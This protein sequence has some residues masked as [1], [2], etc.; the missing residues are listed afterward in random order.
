MKLSDYIV[1]LLEERN[2]KHVFGYPGGMI[3][4][5]M[6]SLSHSKEIEC[7]LAYNE[8]GAALAAVGY[9]QVS[10]EPVMVFSSSGPGATN[11]ITGIAD[12]WFDSVPVLFV[13]GNVNTYEAKNQINVRQKGFQEANIVEMVSGIT[14]YAVQ[15]NYPDKV[16]EVFGKAFFEINNGRKGPALIDIP[17]DI[18]RAEV[19]VAVEKGQVCD[20][21][22]S[23]DYLHEII[24]IV[25]RKLEKS[26]RPVLL[27]GNGVHSA[28][29]ESEI[30]K[31]VKNI[32]A[33]VVTSL[34]ASDLLPK[35]GR[36][37]QGFI[38]AY[39]CRSANIIIE[40]SD[41][42]I[43]IG[44]RLDNRQTGNDVKWFATE[45]ELVRFEIDKEELLLN[46]KDN[47]VKICGDISKIIPRVCD[48]IKQY[49]FEE[50][51]EICESI[52]KEL[53]EYDK[54]P[55]T[56]FLNK[57][58]STFRDDAV[59]T[60][61]VGQ[62]Q[63]W[64]P[65]AIKNKDCRR[66]LFSAGFGCMGYSLPA[67]I[68]A[69]IA[70]KN[71]VYC[72]NGDGGLQMNIQELQFAVREQLPIKIIVLNNNSLGMI[73]HF[74][75]LYFENN[76]FMTTYESGYTVP[77]FE[78]IANAYGIPAISVDMSD[79]EQCSTFMEKNKLCL[80]NIDMGYPTVLEPKS[81]YNK[82]L[83][84]QIPPIP[85]EVQRKLMSM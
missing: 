77:Q 17:M 52:Q 24:K 15:L 4:H 32:G 60:T 62:N 45:A 48:V 66:I 33:P 3:T 21:N 1:Q 5:L 83:A 68:G 39:G 42:V 59:I 19:N 49:G 18:T 12:A 74:Q 46:V 73:R 36:Y 14:K 37:G 61:D 16:Q 38:G 69:C 44:S 78:K 25:D 80:I 41:L 64:V 31:L 35:L 28:G 56:N 34:P 84:Y 2:I 11:L 79:V 47:E 51:L 26:K 50:W 75:E 40:K 22:I 58:I 67:A 7:H 6:E 9:A 23:D 71:T 72:F 54:T 63:I 10:N 70:T 82:P 43:S 76:N 65:Q 20:E 8:Q 57:L 29:I 53:E 55:Q 30:C 13:T 85:E 81:I 27:L